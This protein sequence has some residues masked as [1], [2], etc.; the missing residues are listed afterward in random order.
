MITHVG[1]YGLQPDF[2]NVFHIMQ[3]TL[4][5]A[6]VIG[7]GP[8][9]AQCALWLKQLGHTPC[10]L[11]SAAQ[12]GGLLRNN[13]YP[14]NGLL[15]P[16]HPISGEQL[17]HEMQA[18]LMVNQVAL[19][20]NHRAT[21]IR[22]HHSGFTVDLDTPDGATTLS[23][24]YVVIA[25]GVSPRHGGL[26]GNPHILIGPGEHIYRH[27][28]HNLRVAVLGGG[29]NAFENLLFIQRQHADVVKLFARSL[30]ARQQ[31]QQQVAPAMCQ[32]GPYTVDADRC[33]VN[34]EQFDRIVVMYG[35]EPNLTFIIEGD[36]L[37]RAA[38]GTIVTDPQHCETNISGLFAIGE[39][40]GRMHPC[41]ATAMADGVVAA[42]AIQ[43]RLENK[44]NVG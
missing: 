4:F 33:Q 12:A 20:L 43:Y 10:L 26:S 34:N 1:Q 36:T 3:Q 16:S 2:Q 39:I 19:R 27:T 21:R 13:P 23:A 31:F 18:C 6:I 25:T 29:D 24:P 30:S 17:A 5:D 8:A 7:S 35:W 15:M 32:I 38:D 28:W 42:K 37:H 11:D 44:T 22:C 9:G 41:Y 40:T 14:V